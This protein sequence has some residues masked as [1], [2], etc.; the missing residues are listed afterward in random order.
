MLDGT[1]R[2]RPDWVPGELYIGG[3]GLARGYWRDEEKT[4]PRF[5]RH[6]RTGERL[7]RTGDL[8]RYLPDG[9]IEFLGR[10]DGQV[11]I[12]GYRVELGEIEAALLTHGEVAAAVAMATRTANGERRLVAYVTRRA[13]GDDGELVRAIR[14][15]LSA[16]LPAYMVPAYYAVL[17]AMP[18]TGNGKVDRNALAEHVALAAAAS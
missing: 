13:A 8:G 2:R 5:V 15:H 7:Y 12:H 18:L 6:P 1:L 10:E 9:N 14:G 4:A 16:K 3:A 17:D 11:K